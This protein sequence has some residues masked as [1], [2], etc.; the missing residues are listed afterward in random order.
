MKTTNLRS[1]ERVFINVATDAA[2]DVPSKAPVTT[3]GSNWSL[4]YR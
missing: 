1:D 3:G 2:V 4:P